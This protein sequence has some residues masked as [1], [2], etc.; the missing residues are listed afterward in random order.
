MSDVFQDLTTQLTSLEKVKL[1]GRVTSASGL[2][3]SCEGLEKTTIGSRCTVE[4]VAGARCPAEVVGYKSGYVLVMPYG[5]M[6]GFGPGCKVYVEHM[7]SSV[8]VNDSFKGRVI[9]ALGEPIDGKGPL[10]AGG[11]ECPLKR[12]PP[13]PGMRKSVG[14]KL[15]VGVRALNTFVPIC[16]GQRLGVFSGSGVGKSVLMSMV[17][18]FCEAEINVI[19]LVGERGREVKEF[20]EKNLGEEGLK[21]SVVIVAS[22]DEAPLMR[23]QAAYMTMAVAEYFR[24]QGRKVMLFMDSV[25]RF[26]MAQ[27]EVGLSAGEPPTT[28]GFTPS[29]FSEL[30]RLLERAGQGE[31]GCEG[32]I[33]AIFTVLVEGGDMDEP[34]ADAVRGI[35]DG[36]I[37]LDRTLAERGHFPAIQVLKSVSRMLPECHSAGELKLMNKARGLLATYT[38][39]E[40]LIRLGAYAKGSDAKVDEAIFYYE[41]IEAFLKQLHNEKTET[42]EGFSMLAE[43]LQDAVKSEA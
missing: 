19:G 11:V 4:D 36:H 38:D 33:T 17:A 5:A 41:K 29:V 20:I 2:L 15:D 27:R 43:I 13:S 23:R 9:N 28:R 30:P 12:K 6:E 8:F 26:A 21:N 25:T 42:D 14:Q 16:E 40:E 32:S 24:D 7:T 22:G 1:F 3:L 37:L 39:M 34:V 10:R 31:E 18:K 35:V